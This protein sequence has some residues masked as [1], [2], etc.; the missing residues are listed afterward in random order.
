MQETRGNPM[1]SKLIGVAA[2]AM[3]LSLSS[4]AFA[5]AQ[6]ETPDT[7]KMHKTGFV[8]LAQASGT[9]NASGSGPAATTP[10]EQVG[11]KRRTETDV[12][13]NPPSS[14]S[15]D[16]TGSTGTVDATQSKRKDTAEPTQSGSK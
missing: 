10:E 1:K 5:A 7:G 4:G 15:T 12:P 2:S 11:G 9:G 6:L 16:V 8:T 13:A 14:S 3:M